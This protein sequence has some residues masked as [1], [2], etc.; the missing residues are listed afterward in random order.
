MNNINYYIPD[1]D[2]VIVQEKLIGEGTITVRQGNV[3]KG[4]FGVNDLNNSTIEIEAPVNPDLDNYLTKA[5]AQSQYVAKEGY[6]ATDNNYTS[7]DKA[8]VNKALTTDNT[9]TLDLTFEYAN[10]TTQ[11][12]PFIIAKSV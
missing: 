5:E 9:E 4:T 6:V 3:T 12:I 7:A 11:T 1:S 8:I 10:E 2:K